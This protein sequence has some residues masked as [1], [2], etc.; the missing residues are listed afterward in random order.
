MSCWRVLRRGDAASD[1]QR[2]QRD[3]VDPSGDWVWSA[4]QDN[5]ESP[6]EPRLVQATFETYAPLLKLEVGGQVIRTTATHPFW[7]RGD[8]WRAAQQLKPGDH[9]RS[10]DGRWV[11]VDSVLECGETTHVYNLE[12]AQDHTY[13]VGGRQWGFSVWA[14]NAAG[15]GAAMAEG[16][17]IVAELTAELQACLRQ[18]IKQATNKGL[19]NAQSAVAEELPWMEQIFKG[20]RV[21]WC[22]RQAFLRNPKLMESGLQMTPRGVFGPDVFSNSLKVWW[23]VTTEGQWAAHVLKY[24]EMFGKGIEGL[25]YVW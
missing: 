12:V 5:P 17:S 21:D 1:A 2:K 16:Q 8:G 14:H 10:H 20:E 18:G 4:P 24:T 19:T 15:C 3:R 11:A 6:P 9:L 23:D 7:V 13:F 22:F 25:G